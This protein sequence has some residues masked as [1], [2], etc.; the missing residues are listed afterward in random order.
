MEK[1]PPVWRLT[2]NI[3]Q[4]SRGQHTRG[5]PLGLESGE[6]VTNPHSKNWSC[7]ETDSF[8]SGLDRSFGTYDI[9]NG[10]GLVHGM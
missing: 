7:Y 3:L 1:R 5:G 9:S 4:S 2:A 8:A 10:T 6:M